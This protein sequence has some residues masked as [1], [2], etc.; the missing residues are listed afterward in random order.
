MG[1][2]DDE[3][4]V[5]DENF[6]V[7]AGDVVAVDDDDDGIAEEELAPVMRTSL[8]RFRR[9][10]D[11]VAELAARRRSLK[12]LPLLPRPK[13]HLARSSSDHRP[14]FA[15]AVEWIKVSPSSA[16]VGRL[17]LLQLPQPALPLAAR[18]L[19]TSLRR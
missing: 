7:V 8:L 4:D 9:D 12:Q 11:G 10:A 6:V 3:E 14:R 5:G 2:D 17:W 13:N 18:L 1:E 19:P 15:V 16:G